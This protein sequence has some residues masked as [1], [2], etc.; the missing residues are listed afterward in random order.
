MFWCAG[1]AFG[2]RCEQRS[3]IESRAKQPAK[4]ISKDVPGSVTW[5]YYRLTH[6]LSHR[7]SCWLGPGGVLVVF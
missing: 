5:A 6:S 7:R 2:S 3:A 1:D 4:K